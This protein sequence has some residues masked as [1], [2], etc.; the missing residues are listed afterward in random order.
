VELPDIGDGLFDLWLRD[1][2]GD[3]FDTGEDIFAGDEFLFSSLGYDGG[4]G[5]FRILGIEESAGLDPQDPTAFVT[6]L[7]FVGDGQFTGTMT[8]ITTQVP[9]PSTLFLFVGG[10]AS[11]LVTLRAKSET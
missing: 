9:L 2:A 7:T 11:V 4:V 5:F 1:S 10:L 8:P 6:G 3:I